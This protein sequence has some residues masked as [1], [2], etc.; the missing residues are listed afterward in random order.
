MEQEIQTLN[1]KSSR[2]EK[3]VKL[4][5]AFLSTLSPIGTV[6]STV[7]N[8]SISTAQQSRMIDCINEL[9]KLHQEQNN[10][11]EDIKKSFEVMVST[12][13]NTLLFELAMKAAADTNSNMLHHCYA[14]YIFNTVKEKKRNLK[15][16]NMNVYSD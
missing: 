14:Y 3:Y 10:E 13:A 11:I 7:I 9:I 6:I 12:V 4:G 16:F 5:S 2:T 8:E 15:M 1:N